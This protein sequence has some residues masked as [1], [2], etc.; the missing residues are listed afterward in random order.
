MQC[1]K[2]YFFFFYRSLIK[3]SIREDKC[4]DNL[5][6]DFCHQETLTEELITTE[7]S[8]PPCTAASQYTWT[9]SSFIY[10]SFISHSSHKWLVCWPWY[11]CAWLASKLAWPEPHRESIKYCQDG[12]DR[13]QTQQYR[14]A[15]GSYQISLGFHNTSSV[16][17]ADRLHATPPRCSNSCKRSSCNIVIFWVTGFSIFISHKL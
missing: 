12:D 11:H 8:V 15:E 7:S 3:D 5:H 4:V 9:H 17:Q 10:F 14:L 16:S 1:V 2:M 13:H 6:T